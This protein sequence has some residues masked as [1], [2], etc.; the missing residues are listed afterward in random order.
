[1]NEADFSAVRTWLAELP[2]TGPD[3]LGE[4]L[5]SHPNQVAEAL[6]QLEIK[7]VNRAVLELM[8][9]ESRAELLQQLTRISDSPEF[10]RAF[11]E[12]L[13]AIWEQ[14]PVFEVSYRGERADGEQFNALLGTTFP[15]NAAGDLIL[16]QGVVSVTD[17]TELVD[18]FELKDQL[19][20]SVGHELATPLTSVAGFSRELT[21]QPDNFDD[22]ERTQA[23]AIIAQEADALTHVIDNLLVAGR[24]DLSTL[25]LRMEPVEMA[26]FLAAMS[27]NLDVIRTGKRLQ[28]GS[29][30]AVVYADPHRLRQVL[31][32]LIDNA[33]TYGGDEISIDAVA[34]NGRGRITVSDNGSGL[35]KWQEG[36]VFERYQRPT[37]TKGQPMSLGLGLPVA[38]RLAQAMGGSL[39]YSRQDGPITFELELDLAPENVRSNVA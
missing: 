23:V 9:V 17:L 30:E 5:L 2:I 37:R 12:Q 20:A 18:A 6:C 7:E 26:T 10:V 31:R 25:K 3:A 27:L 11:A 21:E 29:C 19:L 15:V 8:R 38:F 35:P 32:N 1:M 22:V 34:L 4:H 16:S 13:V 39:T 28:F 36:R 33:S 24:A 14:Q